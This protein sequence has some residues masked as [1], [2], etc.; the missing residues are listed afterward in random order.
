MDGLMEIGAGGEVARKRAPRPRRD[1]WE[2]D[3]RG[4]GSRGGEEAPLLAGEV[5]VGDGEGQGDGCGLDHRMTENIRRC[6]KVDHDMISPITT[7]M[8]KDSQKK[9]SL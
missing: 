6:S 9:F 5:E 1:G 3:A 2:E 8:I 4:G 7:E